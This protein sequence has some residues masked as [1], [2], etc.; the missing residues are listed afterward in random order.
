MQTFVNSKLSFAAALF[1]SIEPPRD[2]IAQHQPSLAGQAPGAEP[3]GQPEQARN[4]TARWRRRRAALSR[5]YDLEAPFAER[6]IGGPASFLI[7]ADAGDRFAKARP[8]T[9]CLAPRRPVESR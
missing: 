7:R 4:L 2:Q 3:D 5:A 8:P 6:I 9:T 1:A